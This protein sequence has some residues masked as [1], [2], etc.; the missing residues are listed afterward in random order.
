MYKFAIIDNHQSDIDKMVEKIHQVYFSKHHMNYDC[1][2]YLGCQTFPFDKYYDAIFLDIEMPEM[3]GFAFAKEINQK[4]NPK[5]IFMTNHDNLVM[6]VFDYKPF[7]FIQKN[8]FDE[9][10]THVLE[11]LCD[12]LLNKVIK[13]TNTNNEIDF[14]N[15]SQITYINIYEGIVT[16]HTFNNEIYTTWKSLTSIYKELNQQLFTYINQSTI[17]NMKYI[18]EIDPQFTHLILKDRTVFKISTRNKS[19]FKKTY[20]KFRLQ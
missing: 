8:K 15:Q 2:T 3:D 14:V 6:S 10:S 5:I 19:T 9:S 13:V 4:Y 12:N 16:L 18:K 20:I 17:V 1:D 7:H 11:L